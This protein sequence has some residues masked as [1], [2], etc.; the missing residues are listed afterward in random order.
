MTSTDFASVDAFQSN[1]EEI[2]QLAD[3]SE[4]NSTLDALWQ[5]LMDEGKIPYIVGVVVAFV[6]RGEVS[7][8]VLVQ[9][10]WTWFVR[11][12][13]PG[14]PIVAEPI[15]GTDVWLGRGQFPADARLDYKLVVDDVWIL[16]P[17]NPR[18][19]RSGFGDNSMFAMPDYVPS[20]SS[21]VRPEVAQGTLGED[22]V[23][24]SA[25]LGYDVNYRVYVPAGYDALADLPVLYITDGHEYL[26]TEMG[27]T[28]IVLDNLIADGQIP[29]TMAVF[30][31]PRDVNTGDNQRYA[32]YFEEPAK[33]AE[34]FAE[35][36][37]PAID[38]A[39][40]TM[41]A[42]THRAIVGTSFGGKFSTFTCFHHPDTFGLCLIQ[43]PDAPHAETAE[44]IQDSELLPV[45]IALHTGTVG[46]FLAEPRGLRDLLVSKGYAPFYLEV[47]QGHSWG[48]W[49]DVLDEMLIALLAAK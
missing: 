26:H 45:R 6:Y 34:F 32:Q 2:A 4:R 12:T 23:I 41:A 24:T 20:P 17:A 15:A 16:D 38:S 27:K 21:Q 22:Q 28:T 1:L 33:T 13:E 42:A 48:N 35:E 39:Y 40:T 18:T 30:V 5:N 11:A 19:Q 44:I 29:P 37:V 36:L 8:S 14:Q 31:D 46:D 43:S 7:D 10:D 47:S 9:G 3:D 25:V 49:S